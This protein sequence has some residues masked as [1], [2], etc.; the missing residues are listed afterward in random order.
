MIAPKTFAIAA[1][2]V[3]TCYLNLVIGEEIVFAAVN[4]SVFETAKSAVTFLFAT[5]LRASDICA[6]WCSFLT[7]SH[8]V[9]N[10]MAWAV[11]AYL[12]IKH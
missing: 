2:V 3:W 8:C 4:Q 9:S 1:K 10:V 6:R 7:F 12:P 11:I 5:F